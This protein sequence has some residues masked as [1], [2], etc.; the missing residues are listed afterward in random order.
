M[1]LPVGKR[2]APELTGAV[3]VSVSVLAVGVEVPPF[4][5]PPKTKNLPVFGDHVVWDQYHVLERVAT[6]QTFP[7]LL[8]AALDDL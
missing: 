5:F 7:F 3:R 8:T 6:V 1:T 2:V 4:L